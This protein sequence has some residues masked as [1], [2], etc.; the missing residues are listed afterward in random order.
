VKLL[1]ERRPAKSLVHERDLPTSSMPTSEDG[2]AARSTI[3][4][5]MKAD[6]LDEEAEEEE[7][8]FSDKVLPLQDIRV[9]ANNSIARRRKRSQK[10]GEASPGMTWGAN[11]LG[12]TAGFG[13]TTGSRTGSVLGGSG[14][15]PNDDRRSSADGIDAMGVR[16]WSSSKPQSVHED[17]TSAGGSAREGKEA[18][19]A[20]AAE[21]R[22]SPNRVLSILAAKSGAMQSDVTDAELEAA[23]LKRYRM[24][25]EEL[26][27]MSDKM[28]LQL[29]NLCF[30]KQEFDLYDPD[31]TGFIDRQALKNLMQRLGEAMGEKAETELDAAFDGGDQEIEF[32][33]FAEWF[34]K[35]D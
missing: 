5:S 28:G 34:T 23:F 4:A 19:K 20:S 30:L 22:Q 14:G 2:G 1:K 31:R 11:S 27:L 26:Q 6:I 18:G 9:V 8:A 25:R 29:S 12:S 17:S 24:S 3:S 15:A 10:S 16:R 21:V 33:E 13:S 35:A 7:F 32:F